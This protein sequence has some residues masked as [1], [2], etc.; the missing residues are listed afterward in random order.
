MGTISASADAH[1][2]SAGSTVDSEMNDRSATTQVD[3][4]ADRV[5]SQLAHVGAFHDRDPLDPM[6]SD[7]ASWP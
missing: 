5:G 6:R 3:G 7:Q 4:A 2:V 1:E